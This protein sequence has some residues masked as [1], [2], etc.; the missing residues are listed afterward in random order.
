MVSKKD[1]QPPIKTL[2]FL[3]YRVENLDPEAIAALAQV[4][5]IEAAG[6]KPEIRQDRHHGWVITDLRKG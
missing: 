2:D 4:N 3:L 5:A 6:G 1:Q